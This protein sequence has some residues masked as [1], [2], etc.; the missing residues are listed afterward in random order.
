MITNDQVWLSIVA[1]GRSGTGVGAMTDADCAQLSHRLKNAAR[2]RYIVGSTS[3]IP[4]FI[5][6]RC[7]VLAA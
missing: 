4:A 2:I 7:A 6:D 3:G 5:E 1:T